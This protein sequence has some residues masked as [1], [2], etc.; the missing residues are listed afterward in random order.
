MEKYSAKNIRTL[1]CVEAVR[2]RPGMYFGKMDM[3]GFSNFLDDFFSFV[4]KEMNAREF[5]LLLSDDWSGKIICKGVSGEIPLGIYDTMWTPGRWGMDA[6]L[7]LNAS[8]GIFD[9]AL[10]YEGKEMDFATFEKGI[11]KVKVEKEKRMKVDSWEINFHLDKGVWKD[12]VKWNQTHLSEVLKKHAFLRSGRKF[13]LEYESDGECFKHLFLFENGLN[14]QM[15]LWSLQCWGSPVLPLRVE[16]EFDGFSIDCVLAFRTAWVDKPECVSYVNFQETID[17]GTHVQA[18]FEGLLKGISMYVNKNNRQGDWV[19]GENKL[20]EELLLVLHL[21]H[22]TA[23]YDAAVKN[24]LMNPEIV[25]PISDFVADLFYE[26]LKGCPDGAEE[27]L[28]RFRLIN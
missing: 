16:K 15:E 21:E 19:V 3:R 23:H 2:L 20:K 11:R 28:N 13:V 18:L 26:K 12:W 4:F 9:A 22:E 5:R 24:K 1:N 8:S 7:C 6:V 14:A 27:I 25:I 17:G 10:Y